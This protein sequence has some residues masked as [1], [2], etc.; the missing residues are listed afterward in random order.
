MDI[1]LPL[2]QMTVAEKLRLMEALWADLSRHEADVE[3]PAWHEQILKERD[4][5][6]KSG[7][8]FPLDWE[9][10]KQRIRERLA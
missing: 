5:R 6:L 4:A 3:S 7:Q 10:A 8:E 2:E 1:M 9:I